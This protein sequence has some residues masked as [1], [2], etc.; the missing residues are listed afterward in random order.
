MK[1]TI[2][3]APTCGTARNTL[4]ILKDAGVDVTIVEYLKTPPDRATLAALYKRAGMTPAQGLR[5]KEPEAAA[6]KAASDEIVLDAMMENPRLI[7][8]PLVETDRG[9]VLA[10]PPE[11]VR[12]IL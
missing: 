4:A 11:R 5:S 10:R 2:Y 8:R 7:E 1:A 12:D 6:L 3:Y 9:V